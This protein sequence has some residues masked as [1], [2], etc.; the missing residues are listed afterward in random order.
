MENT[1]VDQDFDQAR[2][3]GAIHNL[4][5]S[6]SFANSIGTGGLVSEE[7]SPTT[8]EQPRPVVGNMV[9]GGNC[10]A[11]NDLS[12]RLYNPASAPLPKVTRALNII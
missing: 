6:S 2:R 3:S 4:E 10:S 1:D 7:T 11:N 12:R 8:P 5:P 9:I